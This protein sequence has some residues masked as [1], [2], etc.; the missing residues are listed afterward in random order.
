[1]LPFSSSCLFKNERKERWN[2]LLLIEHGGDVKGLGQLFQPASGPLRD[3]LRVELKANALSV[4]H[5]LWL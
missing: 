4:E 3:G 5:T 2:N 1:M